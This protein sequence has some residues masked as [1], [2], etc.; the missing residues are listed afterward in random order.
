M[1]GWVCEWTIMSAK[2]SAST[3]ERVNKWVSASERM[4]KENTGESP[5]RACQKK[6]W[7]RSSLRTW[8]RP[9]ESF[10]LCVSVVICLI[11]DEREPVLV[12]VTQASRGVLG[13]G[14]EASWRGERLQNLDVKRNMD[15]VTHLPQYGSWKDYLPHRHFHALLRPWGDMKEATRI[16]P[17]RDLNPHTAPKS[18]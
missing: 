18:K 8:V 9:W 12:R 3:S 15:H 13:D 17:F 14:V 11:K 10:S 7:L 2:A 5:S 6:N 4:T 1:T 16:L